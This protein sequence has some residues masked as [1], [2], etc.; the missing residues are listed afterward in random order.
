[1][2]FVHVIAMGTTVHIIYYQVPIETIHVIVLETVAKFKV[3]HNWPN[4]R[5]VLKTICSPRTWTHSHNYTYTCTHMCTNT[6]T[7]IYKQACVDQHKAA[8]SEELDGRSAFVYAKGI[9]ITWSNVLNKQILKTPNFLI[10]TI[11]LLLRSLICASHI[12]IVDQRKFGEKLYPHKRAYY[13]QL[14][15]FAREF[16]RRRKIKI[17]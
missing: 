17:K 10:S 3:R 14:R 16:S 8:E 5:T 7:H 2:E 6:R 13:T 9:F 11:W 1:M 12:I 4:V 15:K